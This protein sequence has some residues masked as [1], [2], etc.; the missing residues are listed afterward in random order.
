MTASQWD[1]FTVE[2]LTC[3]CGCGRMEMNDTFMRLLVAIRKEFGI[4]MPISSAYRCPEHNNNVSS[5]GYNGPHTTGCAVDTHNSRYHGH[6]LTR[7]ALAHGIEGV[8]W[9]QKGTTRFIHLDYGTGLHP[10]PTIWSY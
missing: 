9:N 8:G 4:P 6:A 3:K 1:H 7:I 10:R 2:E 5:T